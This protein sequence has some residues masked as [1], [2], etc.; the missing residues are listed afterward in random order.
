MS[1][2]P[3]DYLSY[4]HVMAQQPSVCQ[5]SSRKVPLHPCRSLVSP[6]THPW[7]DAPRWGTIRSLRNVLSHAARQVLTI[8]I[9]SPCVAI[10]I[11]SHVS[12]E[13]RWSNPDTRNIHSRAKGEHEHGQLMLQKGFFISLNG[14]ESRVSHRKNTLF[15]LCL[16]NLVWVNNFTAV[17]RRFVMQQENCLQMK[18]GANKN[19]PYLRTRPIFLFHEEYS[20]GCFTPPKR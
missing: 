19:G 10:C 1:Y 11:M 13:R 5:E 16:E 6:A 15:I 2:F 18:L 20:T 4:L 12:G 3:T 17:D 14:S 8:V 7:Q 9:S